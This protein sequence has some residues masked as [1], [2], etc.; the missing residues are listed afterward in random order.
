MWYLSF[1]KKLAES[2]SFLLVGFVFIYMCHYAS[3]VLSPYQKQPFCKTNDTQIRVDTAFFVH[4]RSL[5][6][7][8]GCN[9]QLIFGQL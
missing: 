3:D 6:P 2:N 7:K 9:G 8:R 4:L 1:T 5:L